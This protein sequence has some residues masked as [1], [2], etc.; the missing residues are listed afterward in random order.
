MRLR[1]SSCLL[2]S[3][4]FPHLTHAL[5]HTAVPLGQ[6]FVFIVNDKGSSWA[7]ATPGFAK[8]L[9]NSHLLQMRDFAKLTG[10]QRQNTEVRPGVALAPRCCKARARNWAVHG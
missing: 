2:S 3:A 4:P 1:P 9:A 6:V 10:N 8:T 7:Y 5:A